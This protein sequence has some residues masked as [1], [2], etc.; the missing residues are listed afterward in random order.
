MGK[1]WE[2]N[3]IS[4]RALLNFDKNV[5]V[6]TDLKAN[7]AG[8]VLLKEGVCLGSH[9]NVF[10][11]G[12]SSITMEK[13]AQMED[14]GCIELKADNSLVSIGESVHLKRFT[15]IMSMGGNITIQKGVFFNNFCSVNSLEKIDIG[16]NTL[17]GENVKIYDHNH[18]YANRSL[19]VKDQGYTTGPIRIG[20]NCWIGSNV[21]ILKN[22]TIGDNCVIGANNLIYKSVPD[23]SVVK[24]G[25]IIL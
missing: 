8:T 25:N 18:I 9:T 14:F 10:L 23:N 17:L 13:N 6:G 4:D 5:V 20:K 24:S 3:M 22:V 7:I 19:A 16:E 11:I 21:V 1:R 2:I 15:N 12:S